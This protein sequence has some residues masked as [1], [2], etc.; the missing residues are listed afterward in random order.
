MA[1]SRRDHRQSS[2]DIWPGFVDA[3]STLLLVIIFLLVVFVLGQFFLSQALE[4]KDSKLL[5]LEQAIAEL[6]DQLGLEQDA[7]AELRRSVAQLTA[8]LQSANADR[9]DSSASLAEI[10]AER[11]DYRDR[12]I[13]LEE[14]KKLLAQTLAELRQDLSET[15]NLED[16]LVRSQPAARR[17][18]SGARRG[19]SG[20]SR[21]TRRRSRRGSR[22]WSSSGATSRP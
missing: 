2:A 3:L 16:D 18:R 9:D 14:D 20:P 5:S 8:D 15:G 17:A 4:G 11:D 10:E 22:S 19:A 7:N 1:R 13:T 12:L 6:T 21:P